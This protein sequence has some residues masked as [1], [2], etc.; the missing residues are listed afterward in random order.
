MAVRNTRKNIVIGEILQLKAKRRSQFERCAIALAAIIA[1]VMG[2]MLL[3]SM[4][5]IPDNSIITGGVMMAITIALAV[6]GGTASIEATKC[7]NTINGLRNKYG[8]TDE[9]IKNYK[10]A[11]AEE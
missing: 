9:D 3:E 10:A 5:I 7:S 8:V 11:I 2:R 1:A 4:G 6:V